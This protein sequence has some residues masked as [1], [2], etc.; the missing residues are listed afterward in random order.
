MDFITSVGYLEGGDSREKAGLGPGGPWRVITDKA[1]FG[2]HSET[3]EMQV[4]SVHP[5]VTLA[6]VLDSMGFR[7][8]VPK[9]ISETERPTTEQVQLI[10][11]A[12]DPHH[13][14]LVA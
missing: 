4:Q 8:V 2:F 5:G 13:I 1:V 10:R 6:E 12:I 14:L 9:E 3:K 11:Q 7:P